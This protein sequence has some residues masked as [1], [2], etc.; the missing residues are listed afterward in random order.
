MHVKKRHDSKSRR[1]PKK[2]EDR[3]GSGEGRKKKH[4]K[5]LL[6]CDST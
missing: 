2:Q 1:V 6:K 3:F 5:M 4:K